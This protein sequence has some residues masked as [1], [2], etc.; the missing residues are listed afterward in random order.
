MGK[1]ILRLVDDR[2]YFE[3]NFNVD[4]IAEDNNTI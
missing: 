2:A 4:K 3:T 1:L